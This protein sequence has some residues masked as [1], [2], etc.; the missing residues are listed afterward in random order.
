[1]G[2]GISLKCTSCNYK[3]EFFLGVGM[4]FPCEYQDIVED[5]R[6]GEYGDEWQKFFEENAGAAILAEKNLYHCPVC[7][8]IETD[9]NLSLYNN[10]NGTP[11]ED[12]Y[13][14]YWCDF[15]HEY[16]L[17]KNYTHI[18]PKC[19]SQMDE[20]TN[21]EIKKLPCPSCSKK[22][23]RRGGICWD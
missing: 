13:W 22:L 6:R 7:N 5:I 15:D 21:D 19:S 17:V 9:Y 16:E 20:V 2:S 12:D 11:P 23:T 14:A 3:E 18:C 10:K 4:M 8:H 1:M